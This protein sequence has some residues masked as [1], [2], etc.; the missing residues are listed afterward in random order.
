VGFFLRAT[1]YAY[2]S[3][4][5]G[6]S[7]D[8]KNIDSSS[9]VDYEGFWDEHGS[10]LGIVP[11]TNMV[12]DQVRPVTQGLPSSQTLTKRIYTQEVNGVRV[13]GGE[14]RMTV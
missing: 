8:I 7:A 4:L 12:L 9:S 11:S 10:V 13:F 3:K 2:A 14:M 5:M 6:C 1:G